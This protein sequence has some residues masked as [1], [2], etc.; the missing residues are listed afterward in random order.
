MNKET[1]TPK[2]NRFDPD[3]FEKSFDYINQMH[4]VS[5]WETEQD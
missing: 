5:G 3:K 1:W 4:T 2:I